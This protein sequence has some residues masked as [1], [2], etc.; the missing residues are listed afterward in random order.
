MGHFPEEYRVPGTIQ[1]MSGIKVSENVIVFKGLEGLEEDQH[2]SL[3]FP[4]LHNL[5]KVESLLST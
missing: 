2:F 5:K 3:T 1:W 4:F